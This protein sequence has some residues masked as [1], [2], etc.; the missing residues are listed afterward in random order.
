MNEPRQQL[1]AGAALAKDQHRRRQFGDLVHQID[2]VAGDLAVADDE[3]ALALVGHLRRQR[4]HLPIQ[5]LPLAGV[6]HERPQLVVV[7]VFGDV[8]VGAMLHRLHGGF[9]I[10]DRRDHDDLDQAVVLFDDAQHFEAA[11]ARQ[12]DIEQNQVD[13]FA[14]ENGKGRFAAGDPQ[15]AIIALEDGGERVPHPLVIIDDEDGLGLGAHLAGIAAGGIV[16][17]G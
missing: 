10:G 8:V 9:D 1:L 6:P 16:A 2:D 13:V 3:L 17:G 15:H 14:I 11:D 12:P 5:V 4:H 7:E